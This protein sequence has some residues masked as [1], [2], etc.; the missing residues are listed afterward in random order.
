MLLFYFLF[1]GQTDMMGWGAF[2]FI[3]VGVSRI[4][5]STVRS[6][7]F[8]VCHG[9]KESILAHAKLRLTA[10]QI[11]LESELYGASVRVNVL[12]FGV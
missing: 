12:D 2:G 5:S 6:P 4:S 11:S 3:E 9:R 8:T 1:W 10:G 7:P